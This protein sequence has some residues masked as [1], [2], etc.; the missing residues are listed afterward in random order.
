MSGLDMYNSQ[1]LHQKLD[2]LHDPKIVI[3]KK[4]KQE[5]LDKVMSKSPHLPP[6]NKTL[7]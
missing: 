1:L 2:E 7:K 3:N 4:R 6:K 5:I